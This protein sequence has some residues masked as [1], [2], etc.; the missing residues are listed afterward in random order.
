MTDT[1]SSRVISWA[2]V[3]DDLEGVLGK[4]RRRNESEGGYAAPLQIVEVPERVRGV[5]TVEEKVQEDEH[6]AIL[7]LQ[8]LTSP[9]TSC[10]SGLFFYKNGRP[11]SSECLDTLRG[12]R[13][14]GQP[15]NTL[16]CLVVQQNEKTVAK[17]LLRRGALAAF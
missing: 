10:G 7:K 5:L 3:M 2:D 14:P 6:A 9:R 12:H 1:G 17:Y 8:S 4:K 11:R 16:F 15:G 13:E